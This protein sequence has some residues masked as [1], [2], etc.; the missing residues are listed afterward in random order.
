MK[1]EGRGAANDRGEK[2]AW[3]DA[4]ELQ[5]LNCWRSVRCHLER[6]PKHQK[7]TNIYLERLGTALSSAA[8]ESGKGAHVREETCPCNA[9]GGDRCDGLGVLLLPDA[10]AGTDL[11][12]CVQDVAYTDIAGD[13]YGCHGLWMSGRWTSDSL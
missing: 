3:K 5:V 4:S 13:A 12:I 1:E 8:F 7:Q 6:L 10:V 2:C 11:G 9:R